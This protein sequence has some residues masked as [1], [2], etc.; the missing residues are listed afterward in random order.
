MGVFLELFGEKWPRE[1]SGAHCTWSQSGLI[2]SIRTSLQCSFSFYFKSNFQTTTAA[3]RIYLD[4]RIASR[5]E[6]ND[7]TGEHGMLYT[8]ISFFK[9]NLCIPCEEIHAL[10]GPLIWI[11]NQWPLGWISNLF[12]LIFAECI[13]AITNEN[14]IPIIYRWLSAGLYIANDILQ[15]CTK[16]STCS[17][18]QINTAVINHFGVNVLS[19]CAAWWRH[20]METFSALLSICAGNSPVADEFPVQRP[21]TRSFDVSVICTWINGWVNTRE[22]GD[23]RCYLAHYDITVMVINDGVDYVGWTGPRLSSR[24]YID[25]EYMC[26]LNV[27]KL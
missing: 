23:L 27:D 2:N 24:W 26:R 1:I 21:V 15:Y 16:R 13:G 18:S 25:F 4:L 6:I 7:I 17:E 11:S 19:P 3:M 5:T 10:W 9:T 14:R 22:A 20:Q 8:E 12:H